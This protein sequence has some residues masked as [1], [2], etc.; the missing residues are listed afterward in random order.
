MN[1][2]GSECSSG[3]ESGWTTY[4]DN[5]LSNNDPFYNNNNNN[6][7]NNNSSSRSRFLEEKGTRVTNNEEDEDLSMVS[8]ASSGPP[9]FHDKYENII[10][11]DNTKKMKKNNIRV[12]SWE[13]SLCLD[14][15]ASSSFFHFSQDNVPPPENVFS[16]AEHFEG[17]SMTNKNISFFKSSTKGKST[18]SL[19]GR[20]KKQ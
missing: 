7:N 1:I 17:E 14:D 4:L 20:K 8:D 16:A 5:H 9:Y 13:Q 18:G 19:L 2:S 11:E 15:T 12:K 3:C 6:K 10:S